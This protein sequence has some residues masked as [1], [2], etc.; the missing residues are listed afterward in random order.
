MTPAMIMNQ[1]W[2]LSILKC[3][4][5]VQKRMN[6]KLNVFLIHGRI[7]QDQY[8]FAHLLTFKIAVIS[9]IYQLEVQIVVCLV[10]NV[11]SFYMIR[12]CDRWKKR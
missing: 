7:L 8:F 10:Y 2:V 12:G 6:T 4:H 5:S 9:A 3:L 1:K 11:H